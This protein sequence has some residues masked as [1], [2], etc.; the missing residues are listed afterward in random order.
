MQQPAPIVVSLVHPNWYPIEWIN[1]L[2]SLNIN[3]YH[4]R[5]EIDQI[6]KELKKFDADYDGSPYVYFRNEKKYLLWQLTYST[7][8]SIV[9]MPS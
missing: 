1:M 3:R 6:R 9:D 7:V 2:R 4:R 8:N 5:T